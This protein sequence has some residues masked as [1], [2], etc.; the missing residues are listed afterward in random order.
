MKLIS[1]YSQTTQFSISNAIK[2]YIPSIGFIILVTLIAKV[3]NISTYELVA[4]PAEVAG[5]PPY[6]GLVTN[7][8]NLL[9]CGATA[10]CLFTAFLTKL[11]RACFKKWFR[12]LAFS[13]LFTSFLLLDDMFQLHESFP[14]LFFGGSDNALAINRDLQ[15]LLETLIF[16]VYL[17]I[18]IFYI[19]SFRKQIKNTEYIFLLLAFVFFGLSTIV[20]MTP[21]SLPGHYI[22]EEGFKVLGITSWLIY[23]TK[24][25]SA[26]IRQLMTTFAAQSELGLIGKAQVK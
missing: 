14:L 13:G 7:V 20:D 8:G 17:G 22:V 3:S 9:W 23:F 2:L 5:K 12:F 24:T 10:I 19:F 26:A 6:T 21:E 16:S 11:N 18:F 1:E 25:C 4:D 15:N